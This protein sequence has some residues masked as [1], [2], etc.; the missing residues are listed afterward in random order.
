VEPAACIA[1]V[2]VYAGIQ[3]GDAVARTG[4]A[5][6]S[7]AWHHHEHTFDLEDWCANGWRILNIQPGM[8]QH[9]GDLFP[10]TV[11]L[12]A[13]GAISKD[14]LATHACPVGKAAEAFRAG[15]EKSGGYIKGVITL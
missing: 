3:P 15:A 6:E 4:A 8:N 13:A 9:F 1:S 7:F 10:R 11:S 12:M 5:I 2:T 14:R